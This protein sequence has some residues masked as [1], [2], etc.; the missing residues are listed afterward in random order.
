MALV[1]VPFIS[2]KAS[3]HMPANSP[4]STLQIT[5]T[6]MP[7]DSGNV[8]GSTSSSLTFTVNKAVTT[9]TLA[10]SAISQTY[11]TSSPATLTAT[12]AQSDG[13]STAGDVRFA[14][15]TGTVLAT[16]PVSSG[17][18]SYQVPANTPAGT[19]QI[20]A[21]FVP[22]DSGNVAGSASSAV[23]FTV[24]KAVSTTS[25]TASAAKLKGG[26]Y[27]AR[28]TA[29]VALNTGKPAVGTV[30]FYI[31]GV[32]VAQAQVG[33]DGK[34]SATA[35]VA[36]ERVQVR[37]QFTPTDTANHLGSTSPTVTLNVV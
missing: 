5:A 17:K 29:T 1:T 6:F 30:A 33:A 8:A 21:T 24:N 13:V 12:V 3:Y 15:S 19:L 37:A 4:S 36:K 32:Q 16:V 7:S 28:M 22:S 27:E 18:A 20:T 14:T 10:A 31:N 2:C 34:A 23:T 26:K 9:T 11:G 25:L 35:P